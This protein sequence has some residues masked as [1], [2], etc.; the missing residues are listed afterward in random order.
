MEAN[1]SV[2]RGACKSGAPLTV[3]ISHLVIDRN[4]M[5]I[6]WTLRSIPEL[7]ALPP[8]D[9]KRLWRQCFK[10]AMH[11]TPT[12]LA[13]VAV[14][15][16]AGLGTM[17]FGPIGSGIGSGI[18]GFLFSQ[19]VSAQARPYLRAAI[20]RTGAVRESTDGKLQDEGA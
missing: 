19:V 5:R 13:L 6:Y 11:E 4:K 17:L 14:G 3:N 2:E 20:E 10:E 9:R 7:A 16:C 8:K 12:K 1:P 18:R 15:L